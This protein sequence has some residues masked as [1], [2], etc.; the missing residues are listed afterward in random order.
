PPGYTVLILVSSRPHMLPATIRSRCQSLRF[1]APAQSQVEAD[2]VAK[3]SLSR[4]DARFLA[5]V[6]QNRLG[7]ALEADLASVRGEQR[8]FAT[9]T[10][11]SSLQSVANI[12]ATAEALHREERSAEA[13]EWMARWIRDLILVRVGAD[14][15]SLVN[16]DRIQ[17]LEQTAR[18]VQ[19][20]QLLPLI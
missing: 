1:A 20:E 18:H 2:L 19:V 7:E 9:L 3:R 4:N 11:R 5:T 10:A 13:L 12:L 14:Q 17:E 6:T 8:D 16:L 15:T